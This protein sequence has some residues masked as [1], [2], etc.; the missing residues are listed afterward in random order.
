M[1]ESR[2]ASM[3]AERYSTGSYYSRTNALASAGQLQDLA[4]LP[5]SMM[6]A[7]KKVRVGIRLVCGFVET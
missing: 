6:T 5:A 1:N 2:H 4:M 7:A 3:Q